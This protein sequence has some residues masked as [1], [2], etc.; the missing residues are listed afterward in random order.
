[1]SAFERY[2]PFFYR[3]LFNTK[4]EYNGSL[5]LISDPGFVLVEV[6]E[7]RRMSSTSRSGV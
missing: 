1:M 3:H 6:T 2:R 7:G 5:L 4:L